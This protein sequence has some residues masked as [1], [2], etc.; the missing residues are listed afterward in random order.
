MNKKKKFIE[1]LK[2]FHKL[3][4]Y[5]SDPLTLLLIDSIVMKIENRKLSYNHI[6]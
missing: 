1:I 3:S 4:N 5:S 6:R 2:I